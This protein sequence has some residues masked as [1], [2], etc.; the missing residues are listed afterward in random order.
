MNRTLA[1]VFL[2]LPFLAMPSANAQNSFDCDLLIGTWVGEHTYE[3]GQFNRWIAVYSG[4]RTL[5]I[6]FYTD[7]GTAMGNQSGSWECDGV[8]V[9]TRMQEEGQ[10]YSF[11]Y[12]IRELDIFRYVYE[13]AAGPIFTS[14]RTRSAN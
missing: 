4:D 3:D 6:E 11:E 10:E 2:L 7:E 8:Q 5:S 14:Y 13:S 9:I 1:A 12:Q